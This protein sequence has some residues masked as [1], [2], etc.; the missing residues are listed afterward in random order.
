[1]PMKNPVHPGR[2]V[3][4]DCLEPLG[5][6]VTEGAR[7]L[8][9]TRQTLNNV[10][11]AKSG[12]SPGDGDPAG[13][14]VWQYGG[15]VA[16]D[17]AS[18]RSGGSSQGREQNQG[19]TPVCAGTPGTVAATGLRA[20]AKSSGPFAG[21]LDFCVRWTCDAVAIVA[22]P[23]PWLRSSLRSSLRHGLRRSPPRAPTN[24]PASSLRSSAGQ[25][26]LEIGGQ[27]EAGMGESA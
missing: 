12:I 14:G 4:H 1:M 19:A 8:G 11:N 17:A 23:S 21:G 3:R 10:V 26:A 15:D 5:L 25:F 18:L 9:V 6:S 2:I 20:S 7:V 24:W 13:E 22:A 27:P 16:A